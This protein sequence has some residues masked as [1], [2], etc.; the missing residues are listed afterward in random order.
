MYWNDGGSGRFNTLSFVL[1]C[2]HTETGEIGVL[3]NVTQCEEERKLGY[4]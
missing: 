3:T 1:K 2:R 4:T